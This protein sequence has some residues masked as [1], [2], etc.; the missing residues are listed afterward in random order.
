MLSARMSEIRTITTAI[1]YPNG[2]IHIGW[3]WE[4]LGA[5]WLAR[6]WDA[7]GQKTHFVTGMDE[8][9]INVQRAA[10]A[11]NLSP[12]AYCDQMATDIERVLRQIGLR[13]DRFIRT[14]DADHE[15][16]VQALVQ[17]AFD[18]GDV[19][20]AVYEGPYCESCEAFYT[21][22][23]L[24]EGNCPVH[25]KPPKF[26][27]EQNYFFRLSKY[28]DRLLQFYN[29][30][31]NFIQPEFRKNEVLN[32]FK[33]GLKDFSI[34]RSTFTWG[35]PLPFDP[36]HVVYVWFDALV[37]YITACGVESYL[38]DPKGPGA[39]EFNKK[40]PAW[41]HIVGKDISRFH[42]V[43]WPAMLMSLELPLP[44]RVFVHGF[45]NVKGDR[46]SKSSGNVV[47]PDGVAALVG[48]DPLRYYLLADN[49]F[50]GDGNFS[51]DTLILKTNADLSNDFGNLVNRSINMT[52]KYFEGES[53][54]AP[55]IATH[56][57]EV[58]EAFK[59]LPAELE[60]TLEKIDPSL[61]I[62]SCLARSRALNLYIDRMKPWALAKDPASR[63]SLRE[64][65][66]T[67]LEGIR[68]VACCLR[69]VLINGMPEVYRQLGIE[70]PAEF[71][72][73]R[74]LK[75]G[76]QSYQPAEPKPIYPRLEPPKDDDAPTK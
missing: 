33:E 19:Y 36:K 34:S 18:S 32:F 58:I 24:V 11:Q 12:K 64:V 38:K 71:A 28:Q 2:R 45:L 5:D 35:V 60:A 25:K 21:D 40:W 56:S 9:S 47:T 44:T 69:P 73:I 51:G 37:N 7:L 59:I 26:I 27:K 61:Y 39:A 46:M 22:K 41:V 49:N 1:V 48:V 4:C 16:V 55:A 54:S 6:G 52:R 29:E 30:N 13:F 57:K 70:L 3:A 50:A 23:D 14:S 65:L 8:H 72:S 15:R 75:W 53:I 67:L 63:E 62:Q 43:Y 31:P 68:W 74:N 42:C 76:T 17:K 66:Y 20:E 10:E